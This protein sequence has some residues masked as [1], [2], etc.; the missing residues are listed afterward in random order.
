M[1]IVITGAS[2]GFGKAIAEKFAMDETKH[3]V[4]ICARDKSR[5]EKTAAELGQRYPSSTFKTFSCD[6]S[7]KEEV[8]AFAK[9]VLEHAAAPD[10]LVNNTGTYLPGSVH[11]EL[12][13]TLETLMATNLYSAYHLTRALVP[14]MI[15]SKQGH[16]FNMCSIAS[17]QA[18]ANGG[19]YSITKFALAG[20][21]KNLRE[22]MKPHNIKVTTVYPGAA[23]TDSW[24]GSG[25]DPQRLMDEKDIAD[26]VW[27]ASRLSAR[28]CVEEILLRP[29][30]GDL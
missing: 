7:E 25:V 29:Q 10:I 5:L 8:T 17:L 26:M 16:I 19:A 12:D 28:A 11:N 27:A 18:Y 24:K 23:Y 20:F 22:E 1:N 9:W 3:Q 6:L 13:G 30:L 14:A 21:S 2:R 4:L 15:N